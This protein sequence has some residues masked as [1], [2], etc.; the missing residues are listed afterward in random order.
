MDSV[1]AW[2]AR[3]L[4]SFSKSNLSFTSARNIEITFSACYLQFQSET[5]FLPIHLKI[6][7]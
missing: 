5:F 7:M 6:K 2:L 4:G 1:M 3:L